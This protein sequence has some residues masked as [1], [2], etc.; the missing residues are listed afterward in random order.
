MQGELEL[1]A[2]GLCAVAKRVEGSWIRP[3]PSTRSQVE[4]NLIRGDHRSTLASPEESP[5][6]PSM[7][8]RKPRLQ[9]VKTIGPANG[10]PPF[11]DPR[12]SGLGKHRRVP[13]SLAASPRRRRRTS[14]PKA[15]HGPPVHKT[16]LGKYG[17]LLPTHTPKHRPA[18]AA[19][20][21]SQ[22][23]QSNASDPRAAHR[24]RILTHHP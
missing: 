17:I 6:H 2:A 23:R 24:F 7:L 19:S 5:N 13:A 3:G 8:P 1:P 12:P 15:W 9:N 4:P 16:C 10:C 14:L 18:H 11:A 22:R 20:P 21:C